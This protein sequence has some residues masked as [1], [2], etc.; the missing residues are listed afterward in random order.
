MVHCRP[1]IS[2]SLLDRSGPFYWNIVKISR[3]LTYNQSKA[4]F[5][6]NDS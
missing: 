3:M 4:T 5:G 2:L 6:F 1:L